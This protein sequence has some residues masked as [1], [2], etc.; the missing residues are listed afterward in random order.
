MPTLVAAKKA[1]SVNI[2]M[3]IDSCSFPGQL[4]YW[5]SY[6]AG[7]DRRSLDEGCNW[8]RAIA[9]TGIIQEK[10][11]KLARNGEAIRAKSKTI[12]SALR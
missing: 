9:E 10:I 7:S 4:N 8:R 3:T 5:I 6:A 1:A 2:F 11:G 12:L